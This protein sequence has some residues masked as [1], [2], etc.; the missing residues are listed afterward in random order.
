MIFIYLNYLL[1]GETIVINN[2][3]IHFCIFFDGKSTHSF[4]LKKKNKINNKLY[5]KMK[6]YYYHK[7]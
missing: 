4:Y 2:E 5:Q 6:Q 7:F 3:H 1:Q